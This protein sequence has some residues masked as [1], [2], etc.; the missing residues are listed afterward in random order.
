MAGVTLK[1][2][3][4]YLQLKEAL[5]KFPKQMSK[6]TEEGVAE[7]LG[8]GRSAGLV[9]VLQNNFTNFLNVRSGN[10]RKSITSYEDET[11]K[12][13]GYVGVGSNEGVEKYA[14]QLTGET[15]TAKNGKYLAIPTGANVTAS[16]VARENS[17]R[18]FPNGFF[19]T[20]NGTLL[21]GQSIG[22]QFQLLFVLKESVTGSGMFEELIPKEKP[23]MI[24]TIKS[25]ILTKLSDLGLRK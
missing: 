18:D 11:N 4:Q 14:W 5:K 20:K 19:V 22:G 12:F 25:F 16:G 2:G 6:A 3:P 23:T 1:L 10:L 17:P 7:A 24:K 8:H 21:F 9:G 15:V 13:F